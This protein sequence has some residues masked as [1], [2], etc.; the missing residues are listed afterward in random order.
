MEGC[1]FLKD[2]I[3]SPTV[4][5]IL[6]NYVEFYPSHV[7]VKETGKLGPVAS[8]FVSTLLRPSE[9]SV[10]PGRAPEDVLPKM[11]SVDED[12]LYGGLDELGFEHTGIYRF[13]LHLSAPS[14]C[15]LI[16][17]KLEHFQEN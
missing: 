17:V 15:N 7:Y 2:E 4:L 10:L 5:I 12:Q 16:A 6:Y 13:N 14:L 11:V 9:A 3:T 1:S 8:G